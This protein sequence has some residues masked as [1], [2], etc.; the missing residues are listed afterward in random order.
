MYNSNDL[1]FIP[2]TTSISCPVVAD[3][4]YQEI[5]CQMI[6]ED[7]QEIDYQVI[8]EDCQ[9]IDYQVMEQDWGMMEQHLSVCS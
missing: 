5:D 7:C 9:E 1:L 2:A 3:Q 6:E 4:L 8:E